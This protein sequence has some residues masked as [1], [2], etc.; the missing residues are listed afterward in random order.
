MCLMPRATMSDHVDAPTRD[1][2][3]QKLKQLIA[4]EITREQASDWASP[5]ITQ[6]TEVQFDKDRDLDRKIKRTLDALAAADSP[7]TDREY[8]FER[9]DFEAWLHELGA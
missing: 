4:A 9:A 1:K 7:S 3:V 8:L 5:W 2:V 6:Y